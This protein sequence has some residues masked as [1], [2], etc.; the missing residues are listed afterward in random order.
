VGEAN[1]EL[2]RR[3]YERLNA[4]GRIEPDEIDPAQILPELWARIDAAA[5]FFD[6]PEVP[7]ARVY[8]GPEQAKQFFRKTWEI[9]A[10]IR[11]EPLEFIDK[12]HAVVVV[13]RVVGV[14]RGSEVPVEMD[15]TD[16]VWFEGDAIVRVEGFPTREAG[17]EASASPAAARATG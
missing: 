17:L 1:V 14:G 6:R 3:W 13:T 2:M 8:R 10:E 7:D 4:L 5:E 9:F 11:W 16:V 12:G 15:E